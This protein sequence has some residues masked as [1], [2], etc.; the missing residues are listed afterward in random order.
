MLVPSSAP[1]MFLPP[2]SVVRFLPG[3]PVQGGKPSPA[4]PSGGSAMDI[5]GFSGGPLKWS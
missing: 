1:G 5:L 4:G 3:P 2:E